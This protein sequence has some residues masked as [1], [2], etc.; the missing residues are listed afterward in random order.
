M[1]PCFMEYDTKVNLY[2]ITLFVN[3]VCYDKTVIHGAT[4][5]LQQPELCE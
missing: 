1:V 5:L 4:D 2:S 3:T